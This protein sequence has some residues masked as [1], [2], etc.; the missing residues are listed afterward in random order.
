MA[1]TL[2]PA[3]SGHVLTS[4]AGVAVR[5]FAPLPPVE[6]KPRLLTRVARWLRRQ[7]QRAMLAGLE[8]RLLS[9]I[10][11]SRADAVRESRRWT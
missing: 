4:A 10:G 1:A 9:D 8:D 7:Q 3:Q 2:D 5:G 11:V 6:P